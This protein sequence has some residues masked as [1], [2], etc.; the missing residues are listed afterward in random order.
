MHR[1]RFLLPVAVVVACAVLMPALLLFVRGL[2]RETRASASVPSASYALVLPYG[3]GAGQVG[4]VSSGE[5]D[6][7]EP[8]LCPA[9]FQMARDGTLWVL[10][11]INSRILAFNQGVQTRSTSLCD[12]AK[13]PQLF[14]VT[15]SAVL[16]FRQTK[17]NEMPAG[18]MFRF[19]LATQ[20][21]ITLD[22][23]LPDGRRSCPVAV[24]PLGAENARLLVSGKTWPDNKTVSVLLNEYGDVI[25]V[26]E[27]T[28]GFSLLPAADGSIWGLQ[29]A[30]AETEAALPVTA[31]KYDLPR[32]TWQEVSSMVLPKRPELAA[33]R[34]EARLHSLG[35]DSRGIAAAVLFKGKPGQPRFVRF[36]VSGGP[37]LAFTLEDIGL[38]SAPLTK[39]F[40]N[41]CYQLLPDGS[42]LAQYAAPQRYQVLRISFSS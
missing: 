19:D 21:E 4:V 8:P 18:S 12:F 42:I 36:P 32:S 41:E 29:G 30:G 40:A 7:N 28:G 37:P 2:S 35:V 6:P 11:S 10:D 34:S 1:G 20:T 31:K 14:G 16:A 13:T 9:M 27:D 24:S 23:D 33:Q 17:R 39:H 25:S 5:R 15:R 26:L 3:E 22:L 38:D